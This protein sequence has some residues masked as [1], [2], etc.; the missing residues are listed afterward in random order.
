VVSFETLSVTFLKPT[1]KTAKI[2]VRTASAA[3]GI[4]S[5]Y[6]LN[7]SPNHHQLKRLV[8][9]LTRP[10]AENAFCFTAYLVLLQTVCVRACVPA[11][12]RARASH[13]T[14][15]VCAA[16]DYFRLVSGAS[17]GAMSHSWASW[18][19]V[20]GRTSR[21]DVKRRIRGSR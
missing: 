9:I 4:R 5:K 1:T 7:T 12:G 10:H 8:C 16:S 2:E 14:F 13:P 3:A 6:L 20:G 19:M 17:D 21:A 15:G 11:G 18:W